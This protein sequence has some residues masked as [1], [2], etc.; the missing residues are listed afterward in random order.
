MTV[1]SDSFT[2]SEF[3]LRLERSNPGHMDQHYL[4]MR[5]SPREENETRNAMM[6]GSTPASP[7]RSM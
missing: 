4:L 6:L 2:D 3:R 5:L 1:D 7:T